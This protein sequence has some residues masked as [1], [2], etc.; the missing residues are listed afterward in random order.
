MASGAPLYSPYIIHIKFDFPCVHRW[1][2]S[3]KKDKK[4]SEI[5][6][7]TTRLDRVFYQRIEVFLA[8]L[9][10]K[11]ELRVDSIHSLRGNANNHLLPSAHDHVLTQD[12]QGEEGLFTDGPLSFCVCVCVRERERERVSES[13][14]CQ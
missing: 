13:M 2:L 12:V 6:Q 7:S 5:A 3:H 11:G 14:C 9:T 8:S 10:L 4:K 1:T